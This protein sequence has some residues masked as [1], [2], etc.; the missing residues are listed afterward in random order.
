MGND[1]NMPYENDRCIADE[2]QALKILN[3]KSTKVHNENR[4]QVPLLWKNPNPKL[5]TENSFRLAI[6]RLN[7]LIKHAKRLG[8]LDEIKEQVENLIQKGYARKLTVSEIENPPSNAF[9]LPIFISQQKGKRL[10]LI[11]DAAAKVE[12]KS[13]ND[14]LLAGP[15]LYSDLL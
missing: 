12:D 15:N 4:F 2:E 1:Y 10:R 9:Y 14:Y 6:K 8:K 3:E 7:I 5:P 13:L 11:W